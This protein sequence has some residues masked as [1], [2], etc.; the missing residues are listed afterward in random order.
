MW[1]CGD[2][3]WD[4]MVYWH[5]VSMSCDSKV[6]YSSL[7]ICVDTVACAVRNRGITHMVVNAPAA[8]C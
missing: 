2:V 3:L 8:G 5:Q 4:G 6:L 7:K 1:D